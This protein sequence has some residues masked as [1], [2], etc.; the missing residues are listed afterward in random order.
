V[1]LTSASKMALCR[2]AVREELIGRP[3]AEPLSLR[4]RLA[5]ARDTRSTVED[6]DPTAIK[7]FSLEYAFMR[8]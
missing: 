8:P 6:L 7:G 2:T 1:T 3:L 4:A 5:S